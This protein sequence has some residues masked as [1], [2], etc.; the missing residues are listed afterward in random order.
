[1]TNII[2]TFTSA[3]IFVLI[4]N[5]ILKKNRILLNF[6]GQNH[7]IYTKKKGIP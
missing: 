3:T 2:L 5:F 4:I 1:M 6:S 7:Q